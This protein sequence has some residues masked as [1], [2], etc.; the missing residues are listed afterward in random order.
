M[1]APA[2][3]RQEQLVHDLE[4]AH[5]ARS[6]GAPEATYTLFG[7]AA[8]EIRELLLHIELLNDEI[9]SQEAKL[10]VIAD[11]LFEGR[12]EIKRQEAMIRDLQR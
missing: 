4:Q 12:A 3:T 2:M 1:S 5:I 7:T 11:A 9:K 10:L 8:T 6:Y